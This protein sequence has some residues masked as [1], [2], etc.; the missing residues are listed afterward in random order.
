MNVSR[1]EERSSGG[2][3]SFARLKNGMWA[4]SR[5][6]IRMPTIVLVP[7]YEGLR[8]VSQEQRVDSIKVTGGELVA[9]VNP[10]GNRRDTL[11][12]RP[13]VTLSG[14][15]LDSLSGDPVANAIV[16]I[17]ATRQ[18]DSTNAKG[19]FAI[20]N[21]LPGR[22][23]LE[24][25][26]PSLDSA[27]MVHQAG[28]VFTDS[29]T[30]IRVKVPS[31][32]SIAGAVCPSTNIASK[33]GS[34]GIIVGTVI[35]TGD[36]VPRPNVPVVARWMNYSVTPAVDSQPRNMP[37]R[38]DETGTYRLCGV[39]TGAA[40]TIVATVDR[41]TSSSRKVKLGKD[42]RFGRLDFTIDPPKVVAAPATPSA[43][44]DSAPKRLSAF[45]GTVADTMK[46][47][48]ADAE[49]S[50]P[51]LGL[52]T[53]TSATG[54]FII[55][56]LIPG[57]HK[58][59]V[60]RVGYGQLESSLDFTAGATVDRKIVLTRL[61]ILDSVLTMGKSVRDPGM[62]AFEEHRRMG[63]GHFVT[64]DEIRR[65]EGGALVSSMLRQMPRMKI[66][67]SN[68]GY[69]YALGTNGGSSACTGIG[70]HP[71][72]TITR[73]S[74]K[75]RCLMREGIYYVPDAGEK[76]AGTNCYAKV[77]LDHQLMNPGTPN[78]GIPLRDLP[79][80]TSIEAMEWY[81]GMTQVPPEYVGGNTSCG[82]LV[83]HT[84]RFQ[85]KGPATVTF[86]GTVVDATGAPIVDAEVALPDLGL[87]AHTDRR[88]RF[89]VEGVTEVAAKVIARR[90]G[91]DAIEM[92][93]DFTGG[94]NVDRQ[95]TLKHVPGVDTVTVASVRPPSSR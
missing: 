70:G 85:P 33:N 46:S 30:A 28:V 59:L 20:D 61:T 55:K 90:V 22:Y 26:T 42:Q 64:S 18:S 63:L 93:V 71:M 58:I 21:M 62:E 69:E 67:N 80:L 78:P 24:I 60:R 56:G 25:R 37:T 35:V 39:P 54:A 14:V 77:Y 36:S 95:L 11:W 75:G 52:S 53:R 6:N 2:E 9:V 87:T 16:S 65:R 83:V 12:T 50:L 76:M 17:P 31:A 23:L 88:G 57:S 29:S 38:T 10:S 82:V 4:I 84:R 89:R 81:A 72:P 40:V 3:L 32:A 34:E 48:L 5:W 41:N 19:R 49:V 73:N 68:N 44:A 74:P 94:K 27:G 51:E 43:A 91:Y 92:Q 86:T 13:P 45:S 8:V 79:V 47:P 15:V 66:S 7:V 1:D